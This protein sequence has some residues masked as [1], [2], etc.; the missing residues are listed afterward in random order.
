MGLLGNN[1]VRPQVASSPPLGTWAR[2]PAP[3][4]FVRHPLL[5]AVLPPAATVLPVDL[6]RVAVARVAAARPVL[7]SVAPRTR[8]RLCT[9]VASTQPAH[10]EH[11]GLKRPA[12]TLEKGRLFPRVKPYRLGS[13]A[14]ADDIADDDVA[15]I[16]LEKDTF[17]AS[18]RTRET[19]ANWWILRAKARGIRPFP[20]DAQ[21]LK[22]LGALLKKNGYRSGTTY[23]SDAKRTHLELN[24][25][26]SEQLALAHK[27]VAR[28]LTR[29]LG[30]ARQAQPIP[31]HLFANLPEVPGLPVAGTLLRPRDAALVGCWWLLREIELAA[32]TIDQLTIIPGIG[33]GEA[34]LDLPIDKTDPQGRGKKRRHLCACPSL[35]CPVAAVR[36]LSEAAGDKDDNPLVSRVG[37]GACRKSQVVTAL[38]YLVAQVAPEIATTTIKGHSMRVTGAQ[39]MARAGL[40]E[41]QI[42]VYGRWG[43]AAIRRYVR[44]SCIEGPAAAIAPVVEAVSQIKPTT[45]NEVTACFAVA[46]DL[47]VPGTPMLPAPSGTASSSSTHGG[48]TEL[49]TVALETEVGRIRSDLSRLAARSIPEFVQWSFKSGVVHKVRSCTDT[50]CGRNWSRQRG[51]LFAPPTGTDRLCRLCGE[52]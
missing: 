16:E 20:L 6:G 41:H 12:G 42:A 33:C 34:V 30:P 8:G 48:P 22:L 2:P 28:A 40:S 52:G 21:K 36:R 18:S 51:L 17:S 43:S 50:V 31:L 26:W 37:G 10:E 9:A 45:T 7:T 15:M 49:A 25:P 19:R 4:G 32:L 38:R 46:R 35:I 27:D 1:A 44:E 24:H 47:P 29:G 23:V 5:A 39:R 3:Q 14:G 11:R 13:A